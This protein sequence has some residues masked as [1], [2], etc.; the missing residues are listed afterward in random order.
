MKDFQITQSEADSRIKSKKTTW[1]GLSLIIVGGAMLLCRVS[2]F[3]HGVEELRFDW[4][5]V[6]L[7]VGW[8]YTMFSAKDTLLKG[9]IG[10]ILP[11]KK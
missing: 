10:L 7:C 4:T 6:W 11:R 8:G 1:I 2:F 5:N 9:M 3:I